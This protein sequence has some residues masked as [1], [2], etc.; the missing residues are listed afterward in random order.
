MINIT[1][2]TVPAVVFTA[3]EI[4]FISIASVS[5]LTSL[6][7]VAVFAHPDLKDPTYKFL[8][9]TSVLDIAYLVMAVFSYVYLKC[10]GDMPCLCGSDHQY[11]SQFL[12]ILL[13]DYFT[14][15]LAINSI[16]TEIFLTVQRAYM[17]R[18]IGNLATLTVVKVG[19]VIGVISLVYYL[20]VWFLEKVVTT[21]NV[22]WFNGQAY[23]E[24]AIK[25]TDFGSTQFGMSIWYIMSTLRIFLAT[26]VMTTL[27]FFTISSFRS[28]LARKSKIVSSK[29]S[30]FF[31]NS[32]SSI[33]ISKTIWVLKIENQCQ[34]LTQR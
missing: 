32:R 27:N 17:I 31:M 24:Y 13:L 21:G 34:Q 2:Y 7:N 5:M 26:F 3:G 29:H 10:C 28:F 16:C 30:I 6:V 22:Y 8:L 4:S 33:K 15:S 20:P 25:A 9:V 18:K 1:N 12:Y 11:K 19:P 14:S 23:T